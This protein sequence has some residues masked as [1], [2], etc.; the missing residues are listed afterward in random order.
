MGPGPPEEEL[1][2]RNGWRHYVCIATRLSA[3]RRP[4]YHLPL[5]CGPRLAMSEGA[6]RD[7]GGSDPD[8]KRFSGGDAG[9][10]AD[11]PVAPPILCEPK[12]HARTFVGRGGG[13]Q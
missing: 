12:R 1:A 8:A 5:P 6:K 4:G 7:S 13:G 2:S 9:G 3:R 10:A 11:V